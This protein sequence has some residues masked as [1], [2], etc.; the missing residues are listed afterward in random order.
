M[1]LVFQTHLL[2]KPGRYRISPVPTLKEPMV[3][4]E[5]AFQTS[6]E[7]PYAESIATAPS[8]HLHKY[9]ETHRG[10]QTITEH[11]WGPRF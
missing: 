7:R 5:T 2:S 11:A 6:F 3:S 4:M 10:P 9:H 8:C 1:C